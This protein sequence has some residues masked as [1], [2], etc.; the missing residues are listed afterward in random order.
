MKL[1]YY[2]GRTLQAFALGLLP[3]SIW[4]GH[5][6][7]NEQGAISIFVTSIF[8]FWIGWLLARVR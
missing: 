3:F 8:I 6:G 4:I 1:T 2:F 7:H 5:L